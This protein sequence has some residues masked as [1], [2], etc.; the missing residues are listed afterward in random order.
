MTR[1]GRWCFS[2]ARQTQ[3]PELCLI[4]GEGRLAE[5]PKSGRSLVTTCPLGAT[6][7]LARTSADMRARLP[8]RALAVLL[9]ANAVVRFVR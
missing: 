4:C 6:A 3:G 5:P 1:N 2:G 8:V 7:L 9:L